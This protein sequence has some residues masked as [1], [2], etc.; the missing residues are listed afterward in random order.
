MVKVIARTCKPNQSLSLSLSL[1]LSFQ[2][3]VELGLSRIHES[4]MPLEPVSYTHL[5][6]PT[7]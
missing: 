4:F 6:L 3:A 5:T 1:F 7:N 2:T